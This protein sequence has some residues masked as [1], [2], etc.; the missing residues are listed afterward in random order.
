MLATLFS[1][2]LLATAALIA[3]VVNA[4]HLTLDTEEIQVGKQITID[5]GGEGLIN[6]AVLKAD[7]ECGEPLKEWLKVKSDDLHWTPDV[8]V[9]T[10]IV[11]LVEENDS[12][13]EKW[14]KTF[15][16]T[17]AAVDASGTTASVTGTA[18]G[19]APSTPSTADSSDDASSNG[20]INVQN[21]PEDGTADAPGAASARAAVSAG[22]LAFAAF[23]AV[24]ML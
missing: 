3:P 1:T 11:F 2:T 12:E 21:A 5:A 8:P 7:D 18:A 20:A 13:A 24:A 9:G 10:E 22:V 19:F 14:S 23:A 17:A 16:V 4:I 15:K 6:V